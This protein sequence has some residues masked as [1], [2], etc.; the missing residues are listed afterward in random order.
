MNQLE[1]TWYTSPLGNM[2]IAA[3]H[4]RLLRIIL[5]GRT[6]DVM[7]QTLQQEYPEHSL[8]FLPEGGDQATTELD[9]YFAGKR[10]EFSLDFRLEGSL[11]TQKV[12]AA[13]KRVS[14][15]ETRSYKEIASDIGNPGACR[16]VGG[17]NHRNPLPLVIPCHRI[18]GA[19]GSLTGFGAGVNVKRC[20]LEWEKEVL[21]GKKDNTFDP[22]RF[23]WRRLLD[24]NN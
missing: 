5:P 1:V 14:F 9:E 2:L 17:A 23:D 7:K 13:V 15:G 16:A 6:P 21:Y 8:T 4:G 11:F 3:E 18:V 24:R 19:D 22:D 10:K 12:L 20:L